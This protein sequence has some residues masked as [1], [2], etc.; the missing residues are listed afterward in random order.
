MLKSW[1]LYNGIFSDTPPPL[2]PNWGLCPTKNFL[3]TPALDTGTGFP[4]EAA[5]GEILE[6]SFLHQNASTDQ[7]EPFGILFGPIFSHYFRIKTQL[8]N[9]LKT[10]QMSSFDFLQNLYI[11]TGSYKTFDK[12]WT[13]IH[14]YMTH[15]ICVNSSKI[16]FF[17]IPEHILRYIS[18][19]ITPI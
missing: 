8:W 15:S 1:K 14:R 10:T 11:I 17:Q 18:T 19:N 12:I 4:G 7:V 16:P 5:M 13:D 2:I 6:W 9:S 3:L